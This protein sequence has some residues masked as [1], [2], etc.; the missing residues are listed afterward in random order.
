MYTVKRQ[1]RKF[2]VVVLERTFVCW[3]PRYCKAGILADQA[4]NSKW[5]GQA[6]HRTVG[7]TLPILDPK[8]SASDSAYHAH[9]SRGSNTEQFLTRQWQII[10][11]MWNLIACL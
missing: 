7:N 11:S 4:E 3:R 6:I 8:S 1:I 2:H 5:T 9:N 10:R